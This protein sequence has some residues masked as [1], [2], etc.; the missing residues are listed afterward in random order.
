[1]KRLRKELRKAMCVFV[2]VAMLCSDAGLTVYAT[3]AA[4]QDHLIETMEETPAEEAQGNEDHAEQSPTEASQTEDSSVEESQPDESLTEDEKT[5][6]DSLEEIPGEEET[7]EDI[8]NT[9]AEETEEKTEGEDEAPEENPDVED[10]E[11]TEEVSTEESVSENEIED[12]GEN[13]IKT[14]ME[15]GD[16]VIA[17]GEYKE[18][19]NDITWVIDADG[20]LTVEGTGDYADPQYYNY[21]RAPWYSERNSIKYAKVNVTGMTNASCMFYKCTDLMSLDMS[22]FDTSQV[23]DM[24]GMFDSCRN[25]STLDLSSFDTSQVTNMSDMFYNCP[26]LVLIHT[27]Y[28]LKCKAFLPGSEYEIVIWYDEAGNEY[29]ELPQ[30]ISYSLLLKSTARGT[31]T[32]NGNDIIWTIVDGNLTVEG[33]GDF[34]DPQGHNFNRAPWY[35]IGGSI[36][37]AKI[38][39]MGTTNAAYMFAECRN[40]S[41]LDLSGF[42][43]SQVTDMSRMFGN[44]SSL[45]SLDVSSFDTSQVTSMSSMFSWCSSLSSLDLSNFDTSQVTHIWGMFSNCSSLSALDLSSFDANQITWAGSMFQKCDNLQLIHTPCNLHVSVTLPEVCLSGK[46]FWKMPDGTEIT[47]LPQNLDHSILISVHYKIA[48]DADNTKIT[49]PDSSG[50]I[51][52]KNPKTPAVTVVCKI[53]TVSGNAGGSSVTLKQGTDYTVTYE[54]NINAFEDSDALETARNVPRA[55]ITGCGWY[56]GTLSRTFVIRKAAAPQTEECL[57]EIRDYHAGQTEHTLDL[58]EYFA[59]Y[60]K[61]GHTAEAPVEDDTISGSVISGQ[62]TIDENGILT[63]CTLAGTRGDFAVIPVTV[64]FMNYRDALLNVKIM[65]G[66]SPAVTVAAPVANP[67]SGRQ[68]TAGSKVTL[69]CGTA[70]AEVYYMTS[71]D[72][73]GLGDPIEEGALYTEPITVDQEL[74]IRA[75]AKKGY[76]RSKAVMLHYTVLG[77]ADQVIKPYAD[78]AQGVITQGTK[79]TLT[80]DTPDAVIY[81]TMGVNADVLGAVPVDEAHKY[82]QPIEIREDMAVK[83]VARKDGMKDSDAA[84]FVYRVSIPVSA[85]AADPASGAVDQGSYI[86]LSADSDVNIYY[87]TDTSD[88][89]LSGTA[90]LYEGRIRVAGETGS[91]IVIRAVAEKKGIYSETVTYTYTVSGTKAQGLQVMMAG[92]EEYIYTGRAITPAVIVTNNGEELTEGE[93]YTVRYSNNVKAADQSARKAPKIT[94]TGKGN[95]TKSRSITF[96]IKPKDIGDEEEIVG[97]DIVTVSGKTAAPVLF[98]GGEKLT[99]KDFVNPNARQKYDSDTTITITGK[100]NFTGTRDIDIR[101]VQKEEMKKFTVVIDNQALK[102]EPLV[103]DGEEKTLDGYFEVFDTQDKSKSNPLEEYSDYAVIYP[104]NNTDAGKVKITVVGLGEYYGAVTKSYNIK[105]R[106][107]KTEADGDM[108]VNVENGDSYPFKAGG[109]VIPDLTVAC[110]GDVLVPGKDYKVSYSGNKKICTNSGAKCTISFKGNYK[111][112]KSIVRKFNISATVLDDVDQITES[113]SV[114]VG[115]KAYTGKRGA[116]KSVPYVTVNGVLL[117]SSDYKVSYY[118]DP[119]KT[120]VIDG[121]TASSSVD[122]TEQDSQTVYVKIESKGNYEGILTA[123]YNVYKLAEGVIDL[124]KAKV[125]FV[126]GNKAVYTGEG[127]GPDIEILYKEGRKWEK[128]DANDI[129]TYITVTYINNVNKGK[130]TVMINGNG[131]RYVGSKTAVFNIVPKSIK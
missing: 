5:E 29:V 91:V 4:G 116:Y 103:Y 58:S 32:E 67:E 10:T 21:D 121:R 42:D 76:D 72:G 59:D 93:D 46:S 88:P 117:K 1:M 39:L 3:E 84:V 50:C 31:Y 36:K 33:T 82:T 45:S 123:E 70:G 16:S 48:L 52:D 12:A 98:Y 28:N 8:P 74:Y 15:T 69:T 23:T 64:S 11:N 119:D 87:T 38:N 104:K 79:I 124:T 2:T 78:P 105:P 129:G 86:A 40:L 63:Y 27:P 115:D 118:K 53:N 113:V 9:G 24:S 83:A 26:E 85:P 25:L 55:I 75:A 57:V 131:G 73:K 80:C 17:S 60:Q 47:N 14:V 89:V 62:P 43:T 101:V 49:L 127:V 77:A 66:N 120:Q 112:S 68:L 65:L 125:N 20:K 99:A 51:Y 6:E 56:S 35:K 13:S 41:T 22:G 100:G 97:S 90:K 44:C 122:L 61:T 111:G 34:S 107:V 54:N 95:L 130:A 81:Y 114:A 18:N 106:V 71:A 37:H 94:V 128:I 109:V 30:N 108:T 92:G 126:G 110:D 102:E 96:T 7:G 19:G